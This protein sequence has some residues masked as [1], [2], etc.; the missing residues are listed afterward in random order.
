MVER[1]SV[2]LWS[3][4]KVGGTN[5]YYLGVGESLCQCECVCVCVYFNTIEDIVWNMVV[6]KSIVSGKW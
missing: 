2:G 6:D 5:T 4:L 1:L 3:V